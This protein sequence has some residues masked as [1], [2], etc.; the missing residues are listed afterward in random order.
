M[1]NVIMITFDVE[2]QAFQAFSE[3]K[4]D[5]IN[6]AFTILQMGVIKNENGQV[7]CMDGF[8]SGADTSDNTLIGGL[9]GSVIGILGGP[10]GVLLGG[11]IGLLAG[12]IADSNDADDN[13][14][15]IE[16]ASRALGQGCTAIMAL[17]QEGNPQAFDLRLQDF[18]CTITRWDAAEISEEVEQARNIQKQ[19]AKEAK[20]KLRAEKKAE[21]TQSFEAKRAEI[22]AKFDDLKS[23]MHS[24]A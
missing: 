8:D 3:L 10:L 12:S 23:R 5:S 2:S 4:N 18:A 21:R 9:V 15:L 17:V 13:S 14:S 19:L 7:I 11:S 24:E 16:Y 22:R 6:S 20:E 1:E